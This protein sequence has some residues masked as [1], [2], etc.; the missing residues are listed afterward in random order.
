MAAGM[1]VVS[2]LVSLGAQA[3]AAQSFS[4]ARGGQP[5]CT[6]AVP[7]DRSAPRMRLVGQLQ[8]W[9]REVTG[10]SVPIAVASAARRQILLGTAADFARKAESANLAELGPEGFVVQTEASGRLWLLANTERGLQHAVYAFLEEIG[11]RWFFPEPAWTVIPRLPDLAVEVHRRE[12]P[13]FRYRRIWYGW[14]ARTAVLRRD[15]EAWLQHNRQLG[16]FPTDCGHAY[17]RHVPRSLFERHPE[18]FALVN[19]KRQATQL[20]TSNPDVEQR[21]AERALEAFRKEPHRNMVSVEPNDGGGYCECDRC[22]ALGSVSDRVFHLANV[23]AKAVRR[24][25]PDKWVGLYAY[26]G[27]SEPPRAALQ[28]NVYVQVT[29]GFR[30][31]DL[32]FDAQVRAFRERGATV[33]VYD[34]FSVYVW[35]YDLPGRAKAGRPYELAGAIRHYRDL[36]LSTYDAESACNWGPNG[37]G[38]WVA[39]KLMW[40]PDLDPEALVDDFCTRAFGRAAKPMRRLY[41]RWARGERFS[42]RGL[43]LALLDLHEARQLPTG[44]GVRARLDRVAL[45]LHLLRLWLDYDRSARWNQWGKLASAPTSET[46]RCAREVVVFARRLMDTGLI[47]TYPMLFSERF[48]RRFAALEKIDGFDWK[49]ADGWKEERTDV[50][51]PSEIGELFAAD[52]KSVHGVTAVEIVGRT[53]SDNLVALA[54]HAPDAVHAWDTVK[55][56]PLP[57]ESGLHVFAGTKGER[58]RLVFTPFDRGHTVDGHWTLKRLGQSDALAEG[59][60]KAEKGRPT[61]AT[62]EP[63]PEAGILAFDPGTGYWHAAQVGFDPRPLSVWAGRH[64]PPGGSKRRPLRLW[65]PRSNQPLYFFVPKRTGHFV[66]GVADGGDPFTAVKVCTADGQVVVDN[67]RVLSGDQ[68]SVNVP[69]GSDGAVWS[70]A[71]SSLRCIVELYDVPPYLARHPCELLVPEEALRP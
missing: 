8:H 33:G 35:D 39:A 29:T 9:L 49:Q 28:P 38:Y 36:G 12:R 42:L 6:I 5:Q 66:L 55:R 31:T 56:S 62:L 15:Y 50:P 43:K 71:L 27:H 57:V 18:W 1:L 48:K 52:L 26:A 34:Y 22:R 67:R 20:C 69:P 68:V 25:F 65:L 4:I 37:L 16:Q 13:A 23:A 45:Y 61:T 2:S 70:L 10:T 32:S 60:V 59:D 41:E 3:A 47:H 44:E 14:G 51:S 54:D 58:L 19:G 24:E 40:N 11:C 21:V 46:L 63:L 64:D 30:Y 17:E 53:F 7:G